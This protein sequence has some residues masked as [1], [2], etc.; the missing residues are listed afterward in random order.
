MGGAED[1]G[2]LQGGRM[3]E[4]TLYAARTYGEVSYV[5]TPYVKPQDH[6]AESD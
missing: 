6:G 3:L 1:G 4:H 2:E 5:L